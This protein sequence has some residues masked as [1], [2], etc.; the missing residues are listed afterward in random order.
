VG[1][2][3]RP[4]HLSRGRGIPVEQLDINLDAIAGPGF[5]EEELAAIDLDAVDS[6]V[7]MWA[8]HIGD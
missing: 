5:T 4:G 3:G 1:A 8:E 2:T 7:N 6:G